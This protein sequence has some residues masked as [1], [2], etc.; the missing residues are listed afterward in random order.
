MWNRRF[1]PAWDCAGDFLRDEGDGWSASA[2]TLLSK[3]KAPVKMKPG[4]FLI[5]YSFSFF[6][7]SIVL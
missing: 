3:N 1:P 4:A 5:F 2:H 7:F 6:I